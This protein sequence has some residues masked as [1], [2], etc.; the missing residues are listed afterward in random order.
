MNIFLLKA[1]SAI[2]SIN[3]YIEYH[4]VHYITLYT[5]NTSGVTIMLR[6]KC[7]LPLAVDLGLAVVGLSH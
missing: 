4:S 1:I 6:G 7:P 2:H 3:G 5:F